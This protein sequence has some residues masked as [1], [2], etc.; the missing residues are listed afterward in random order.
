MATFKNKPGISVRKN[1]LRKIAKTIISAKKKKD[2]DL[3]LIHGAGAAGHQL[4]H[5]Y[6]LRD[7]AISNKQGWI[8]SFES[9]LVNQKL[10]ISITEILTSAGLRITP[11]HTASAIIQKNKDISHFDIQPI[12]EALKWDCIP[13]LYGEMV[14]DTE[15]GMSICSGDIIAPHLASKL[16]VEKM[17]FA[18]D[19]DGIF[20]RDPH[21]YKSATLIEKIELDQITKN[22]QLGKSH[23]ID[24]TDGLRGK[25]SKLDTKYMGSLTSVEIFNGLK[26]SNFEKIL[27]GGKF[28]HTIIN[29][30]KRRP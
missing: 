5:R 27:L 29:I 24:T 6:N 14:F 9:R 18:S 1:L 15:I 16:N 3:I 17:F 22:A 2:F 23:N 26:S 28:P 19:I 13:L 25:I 7:G 21:Q 4:A 20:D 12:K 8:G 10:D 11:I 30:K